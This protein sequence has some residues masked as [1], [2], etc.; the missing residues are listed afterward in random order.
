M[1][2]GRQTAIGLVLAAAILASWAALQFVGARLV[3]LDGSALLLAPLLVLAI[4]W[5]DV[6][7]FIIAHDAMHGSLA[8][9][10]PGLNRAVGRVALAAYGG[11]VY[12]RL[13]PKH[14]AHHRFPGSEEDPDFHAGNPRA[15][16]AWYF[17]FFRRY[18]GLLELAGMTLLAAA[19]LF[20]LRGP[21]ANMLLFWALPSLLSSLQ[22]FLFGTWLPHRH[23]ESEFVDRHRARSSGFPWLLSLLSCFHF[24][25]HLEHHRAPNLPW[26]RLPSARA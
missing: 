26:W 19:Y 5:L 17:T 16:L 13:V 11:F 10:R 12:D 14:F 21:V 3:T 24:G 25:Y 15:F 7:L 6:G 22:L 18:F 8:P 4:C 2:K 9:G 23:A 1:T 20:V